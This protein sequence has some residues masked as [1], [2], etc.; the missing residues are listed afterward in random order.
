MATLQ[1]TS[2]AGTIVSTGFSGSGASLTSLSVTQITTGSVTKAALSSGTVINAT[3]YSN[4]TRI[5]TPSA[6]NYDAYSWT[7]NK[8][9]SGS[10]LHIVGI[11][12]CF[13][14]TNSGNFFCITAAGTRYFTGIIDHTEYGGY[15]IVSV[16]Q[17]ITGIGSTGN[18]T[19]AFGW[20]ANDGSSN[21]PTNIINQN[22]NE[23]GRNRQQ[24][25]QFI[26]WEIA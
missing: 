11:V 26:V 25:S 19:V 21:R 13:G 3:T 18:I 23:D 24:G 12:P 6:A 4:S 17:Y 15:H 9:N 2:V 14:Q 8:V 1:A 16:N 7:V 22:N 5:S 10:K 20:S